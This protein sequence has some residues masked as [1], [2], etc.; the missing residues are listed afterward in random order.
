M[1]PDVTDNHG[2]RA[3]CNFRLEGTVQGVGFRPFVYRLAHELALGGWVANTPSGAEVEIE[4]PTEKIDEFID[5]LLSELPPLASVQKIERKTVE[6][7]G[8]TRFLIR[9]SETDGAPAALVLPDVA[10]CAQCLDE[11]FDPADRR[12]LYPFTNCTNCGP[13]YSIIRRLPYD[14]SNTTMVCFEMCP[15][16]RAEYG[17]PTNR[18]FHAQPNACP[19]CGPK[20]SL[21]DPQGAEIAAGHEALQH[22]VAALRQGAIVAL[23]GIGGF[24]LLVDARNDQAVQRLRQ[25]KRREEKPFALMAPS[26]EYARSLCRVSPIEEK[27]LASPESPIVLLE[28]NPVSTEDISSSVAPHNPN[29]GI[30]LPYS[31][32]HH[33]L[34]REFGGPLV[35]TSGNVTD[36]PICTS[37]REALERLAGIADVFLTHNRPIARYV[38]D[39]V[40]RVMAGRLV[41]LRR[42]RGYAPLPVVTLD[43]SAGGI[44]AFG[45]HLKNT[46]A[47]GVGNNIIVSQHIGDLDTEPAVRAHRSTLAALT[48]LY[49]VE[50]RRLA[51][52]LHPDYVSTRTAEEISCPTHTLLRVPHHIAHL[53]AALAEHRLFG[54]DVLGVVWDGTGLGLDHTIWGSEFLL[55]KEGVIQRVAHFRAWRALGGDRAMREPRRSALAVLAQ[56]LGPSAA[57]EWFAA[58]L[59]H[60]FRD[61]ELSVLLKMLETGLNAPWTVG[62]GRLFDAVAALLDIRQVCSFEGQAAMELECCAESL[63]GVPTYP[64]AWQNR[65]APVRDVLWPLPP[66]P[67]DA[68]LSV[69]NVFDW[70]PMIRAIIEDRE[71]DEPR[72]KIAAR[73][74]AT[75]VEVIVS[76]ARRINKPTIVL[77]GGCFQN[78]LLTEYACLRLE[79]ERFHVF[80]HEKVPPNDGGIAVGQAV[81]AA[82]FLR[83]ENSHVSSSAGKD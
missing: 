10:T 20:L 41:V 81:A 16:C 33:L 70:S 59:P 76:M 50:L 53:Y 38:D 31:P 40:V 14:R 69:V 54:Q 47:V 5:R 28:R 42:A 39:S 21:L 74:H 34:M 83:K 26:V 57:T 17:D 73:F 56:M 11:I 67:D 44:V 77:T 12:Y 19:V 65:T 46:V 2:Q 22:A 23:K 82:F 51:C 25:R 58:H 27:V 36:E 3:R 52:D 8:E 35:A 61:V 43:E 9:R 24:Q 48:D 71:H 66:S 75:L 60:A 63:R 15:Q 37:T 30:M 32:L 29:L 80:I 7:R 4:G 72:A 13:R 64:L 79:E 1:M 62:A 49:K 18:R 6:P 68:G 78:R 45:A 55:L